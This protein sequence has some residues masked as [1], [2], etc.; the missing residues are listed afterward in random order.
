MQIYARIRQSAPYAYLILLVVSSAA[1]T[2]FRAGHSFA[3]M[4]IWSFVIL[5][6]FVIWLLAPKNFQVVAEY[7]VVF[8]LTFLFS[9]IV[10]LGFLFPPYANFGLRDFTM[11]AAMHSIFF[12]LA[13]MK[14]TKDHLRWLFRLLSLVA[15]IFCLYGF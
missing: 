12:S 6:L 5:P 3:A 1:I 13:T 15:I 4:T 14:L 7:K 2:F 9:A 11:Y 10:F 8:T